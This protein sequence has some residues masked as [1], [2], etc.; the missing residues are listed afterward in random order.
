[1][2]AHDDHTI[3]IENAPPLLA[4]LSLALPTY[5]TAAVQDCDPHPEIMNHDQA[6]RSFHAQRKFQMTPCDGS[7]DAA[8]ILSTKVPSGVCVVLLSLLLEFVHRKSANEAAKSSSGSATTSKSASSPL[9][10]RGRKHVAPIIKWPVWQ[11]GA[12]MR[13]D[14]LFE[15]TVSWGTQMAPYISRGAN[16]YLTIYN[17]QPRFERL[18]NATASTP[19]QSTRTSPLSLIPRPLPNPPTAVSSLD[20]VS[21]TSYLY[22]YVERFPGGLTPTV[23]SV[24]LPYVIGQSHLGYPEVAAWDAD[25]LTI[26]HGVSVAKENL[27]I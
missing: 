19:Y 7:Y 26:K 24:P 9:S 17:F 10:T 27:T 23:R 12:C 18:A 25:Y 8:R 15:T 20:T 13:P 11:H 5:C 22:L 6:C 3:P 1:M 14:H 2:A 16:P 4:R 21:S